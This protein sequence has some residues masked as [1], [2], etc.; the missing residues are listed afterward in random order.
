MIPVSYHQTQPSRR[1]KLSC[2]TSLALIIVALVGSRRLCWQTSNNAPARRNDDET[3]TKIARH[4]VDSGSHNTNE[5]HDKSSSRQATQIHKVNNRKLCNGSDCQQQGETNSN[6]CHKNYPNHCHKNA[7]CHHEND[8]LKG[9]S[10]RCALGY[11]DKITDADIYEPGVLCVQENEC[12]TGTHDCDSASMQT[13]EDRPPP[14]RWQCIDPI[15]KNKLR[16]RRGSPQ[17]VAST[18]PPPTSTGAALDRSDSFAAVTGISSLY[19]GTYE[20]LPPQSTPRRPP[21]APMKGTITAPTPFCPPESPCCS[22]GSDTSCK[23]ASDVHH[24][25]SCYWDTLASVSEC[26][27]KCVGSTEENCLGF[28]WYSFEGFCYIWYDSVGFNGASHCSARIR[29]AD[30]AVSDGTDTN[31]RAVIVAALAQG[32]ECFVCWWNRGMRQLVNTYYVGRLTKGRKAQQPVSTM[33]YS[34]GLLYQLLISTLMQLVLAWHTKV[35]ELY[36]Y[37]VG[38]FLLKVYHDSSINTEALS[39]LV[40]IIWH[41]GWDTVHYAFLFRPDTQ[42]H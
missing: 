37:E 32:G 6:M 20:T 23:S 41:S 9:Y 36:R 1:M 30:A 40:C 11:R 5:D 31:S 29:V 19:D 8:T 15:I 25:A 28:T 10:C 26:E 14:M 33:D 39:I 3:T 18:L 27:A 12:E 16:L 21:T 2:V 22:L 17:T 13:C 24:R 35:I 38:C 42:L 34:I 7:I 4:R